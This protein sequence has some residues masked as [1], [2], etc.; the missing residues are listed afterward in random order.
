MQSAVVGPRRRQGA[1]VID[2]LP[3]HHG[4]EVRDAERERVGA[5]LQAGVEVGNAAQPVRGGQ[6]ALADQVR[7]SGLVR[8]AKV[9][10]DAD[11][12]DAFLARSEPGVGAV[13]D[14]PLPVQ[15]D[16]LVVDVDGADLLHLVPGEGDDHVE[17]LVVP[18]LRLQ[19]A[20]EAG[21]H[22]LDEDERAG[23]AGLA[24]DDLVA[25]HGRADLHDP[26]GGIG[27][28]RGRLGL[29]GEDARA[30]LADGGGDD[31]PAEGAKQPSTKCGGRTA[32]SHGCDNRDDRSHL[33][34]APG[35]DAGQRRHGEDA[36]LGQEVA[37]GAVADAERSFGV[38]DDVAP[39]GEGHGLGRE[40]FVSSGGG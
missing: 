15:R 17:E 12:G 13:G 38:E 27:P 4:A 19:G 20:V 8:A 25:L 7:V 23:D 5:V 6:T 26:P 9:L 34:D 18:G 3:L 24:V 37:A 16:R 30:E 29:L 28:E 32:S 1:R 33:V 35:V 14:E 22:R 10:G 2:L 40:D 31:E 39:P 11:E 36:G 21:V